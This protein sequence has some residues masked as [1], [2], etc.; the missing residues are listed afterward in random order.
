[1][2]AVQIDDGVDRIEGSGLPGLDLLADGVVN[3]G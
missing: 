3:T 1:M 2:D